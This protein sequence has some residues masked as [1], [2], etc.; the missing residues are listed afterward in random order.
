MNMIYRKKTDL[1]CSLHFFRL[2]KSL[3]FWGDS[4]RLFDKLSN[5]SFGL[6]LIVKKQLFFMSRFLIKVM[7]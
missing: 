3:S 7:P 6:N 1:I 4:C 2:Q 5:K